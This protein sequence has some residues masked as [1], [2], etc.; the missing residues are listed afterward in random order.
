MVLESKKLILSVS[1]LLFCL[2]APWSIAA[3]QI[4]L[5]LTVFLVIFFAIFEK[6]SPVKFHIFYI[7]PLIYLVFVFISV[8]LSFD[9]YSSFVSVIENEWYLLILPFIISLPISSE[10][11]KKAFYVLIFSST[12][13]G[14]YGIIQFFGGVEYF[15]DKS[16]AHHGQFY[17]AVGGYSFYLTYA[18][19]QLLAFSIAVAFFLLQ[20]RWKMN[21]I[22]FL[23]C[24]IIL[25]LSIVATFGRSTWLGA[26][27]III[28]GTYL[29]NKKFFVYT[30]ILL[31]AISALLFFLFPDV[32]DRFTSIFDM[33]QN[34]KRLTVWKTSWNIFI[35]YPFFGIGPG[36]YNELFQIF[37]VPGLYDATGHSHNDYLNIAVLYGV[38]ALIAWVSMWSAFFYFALKKFK[39]SFSHN[40]DKQII[41]AGI[42]GLTGILF[43]S[44]FQCYYTDLENNLFWWYL[45]SSALMVIIQPDE[46]I[47]KQNS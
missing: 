28:V 43:A 15:R 22:L 7:F 42:L 17:R 25:F 14:I 13:A 24:S 16:L 9:S 5:F 12:I 36:Y 47:I 26:A 37:K 35:H 27:L 34:E 32:Q 45:I 21:K 41:L 31:I 20:K 8:A 33:A 30:G 11:R 19:N 10:W 2:V 38:F 39:R 18:G 44:I 4:S 29:T 1:Y 46:K 3:M 40:S 23:V 6:K